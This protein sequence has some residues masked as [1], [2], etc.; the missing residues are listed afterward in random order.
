MFYL[1]NRLIP[2]NKRYHDSRYAQHDDSLE[3][4]WK[5]SYIAVSGSAY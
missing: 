3:W 5:Q 1:L 2:L 4:T